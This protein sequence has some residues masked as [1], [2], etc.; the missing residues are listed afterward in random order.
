MEPVYGIAKGDISDSDKADIERRGWVVR[1]HGELWIAAP[2]SL[3]LTPDPNDSRL[4][5][6]LVR[7]KINELYVFEALTP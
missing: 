2:P 1:Q 6:P 3:F 7:A 5:E 4:N